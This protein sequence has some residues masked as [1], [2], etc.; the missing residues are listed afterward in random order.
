MSCDGVQKR[1][2]KRTIANLLQTDTSA[3]TANEKRTYI[4]EYFEHSPPK[5]PDSFNESTMSAENSSGE[6][7]D[8][9]TEA[10]SAIAQQQQQQASSITVV[11]KSKVKDYVFESA[12]EAE[13]TSTTTATTTATTAATT[14]VN[15]GSLPVSQPVNNVESPILK[16]IIQRKRI[17]RARAR[18]S[19]IKDYIADDSSSASA[20][21][22]AD[23]PIQLIPRYVHI[24]LFNNKKWRSFL[25]K[26]FSFVNSKNWINV[27]KVPKII[28][29]T[30]ISTLSSTQAKTVP[31]SASTRY[32]SK[33]KSKRNAKPKIKDYMLEETPLVLTKPVQPT[34]QQAP[35]GN[36]MIKKR[37][38]SNMIKPKP[39]IA[40][41]ST[42]TYPTSNIPIRQYTNSTNKTGME[43]SNS[44]QSAKN[45]RCTKTITHLIADKKLKSA[46]TA[47]Q[48]EAETNG[49]SS[50]HQAKSTIKDYLQDR[51]LTVGQSKCSR[52][53]LIKNKENLNQMKAVDNQ[54]Y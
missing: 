28:Q 2:K 40:G 29:I 25:T 7:L 18:K 32:S 14:S 38:I 17:S 37:V 34:V 19:K 51:T 36:G 39:T 42:A 53:K 30:K 44:H 22:T 31:T 35:A 10:T 1:Y 13:T 43:E 8:R 15:E 54:F 33:L 50:S 47:R 24:S 11:K 4:K 9:D 16:S 52:A 5:T 45:T 3:A 21:P 6:F 41:D 48:V 12:I 20:V 49:T 46:T 26:P 23:S 27:I